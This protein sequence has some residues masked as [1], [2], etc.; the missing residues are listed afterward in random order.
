[1]KKYAFLLLLPILLAGALLLLR[2]VSG[3]PRPEGALP[4]LTLQPAVFPAASETPLDLNAADEAALCTLPEIG[5]SRAA[6]I[7]AHRTQYGPFRS[8]DELAAV[9]GIG[10]ALL[11]I[12][13]PYVT[14]LP[15]TQK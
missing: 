2:P 1:M 5:P 9:E 11:E 6:S 7:V 4:P 3:T 10:T 13:R 14:V 12:I 8:V 15:E